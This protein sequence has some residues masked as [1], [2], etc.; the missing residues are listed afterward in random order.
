M[1]NDCYCCCLTKRPTKILWNIKNNFLRQASYCTT[2]HAVI[3]GNVCDPFF[4]ML[5]VPTQDWR[6]ISQTIWPFIVVVT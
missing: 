5:L 3:L 6:R 4:D 1:L 2:N